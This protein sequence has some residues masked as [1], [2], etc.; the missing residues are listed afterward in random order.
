MNN[1]KLGTEFEHEIVDMLADSGYWVHFMTPDNRGAQPFDLIF[2]KDGLAM[3]ADCK[4]SSKRIFSF[5]RL[6]DNQVMAFEKWM[7]CGNLEPV[8]FVKY[9]DKVHTVP[10]LMLKE[11]G[12][13]DLRAI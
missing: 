2:V 12:R 10:Y 4:T 9:G 13:V 5:D 7:R 6:E 3:A 8:V 11:A 1:K